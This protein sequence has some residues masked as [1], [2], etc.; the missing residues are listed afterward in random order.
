MG[1]KAQYRNLQAYVD[2]Q[3]SLAVFGINP[4]DSLDT[5]GPHDPI[6]KLL[7]FYRLFEVTY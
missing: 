4:F 6:S 3:G 1:A 2:S 7:L 5:L